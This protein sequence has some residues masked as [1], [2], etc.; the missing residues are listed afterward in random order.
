MYGF[1]AMPSN[2][3]ERSVPVNNRLVLGVLVASAAF[4]LPAPAMAAQS[5]PTK[6]IRIIVP[7][8]P[9]EAADLIARVISPAMSEKL[10]Q[11]V[12]VENRAGASGQIGLE[13]LKNAIPDGYTIGV[14]QGGNMVVAPHTYKKIPYDPVKDFAAVALN[15]TNYLAVVANPNVPFKTAAEMI[16]WAKSNPGK[17]T[18]A[19][20]GEGGQPH[21]AFELLG[22]MAGFKFLHVPYKG[23]TQIATDLIGGQVMTGIGSYS[24][25]VGNLQ[26][27]RLRLIAVT[28]NVRVKDNPSLPIFADV[29]PGYDV[30]GWFGIVAP[31]AVPRDVI[32]RLN[33][34]VNRAMQQPDVNAKLVSWGL[35][36]A[37]ESPEWFG[38]FIK[39]EH[40]KYA[41]IVKDIGLQPQ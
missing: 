22:T 5:Y 29:V 3:I 41:K 37:N 7:Y 17:L 40:A 1:A 18:V 24:G 27:G 12:V 28:N 4:V 9:G 23:A 25:Q 35:I 32:R 31:A 21:L 33:Q 16:A 26:S 6:P 20:N 8:P 11:Q 15:A 13:V 10:G 2:S 30:R 38:D 19:T 34:E 36:V 14:G 39:A